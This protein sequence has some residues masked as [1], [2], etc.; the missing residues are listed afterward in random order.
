[1]KLNKGKANWQNKPLANHQ[2]NANST[3]S[4]EKLGLE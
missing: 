1:M 2:N 3:K 4:L